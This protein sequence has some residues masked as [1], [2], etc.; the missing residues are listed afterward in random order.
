MNR[1]YLTIKKLLGF[2]MTYGE[3]AAIAGEGPCKRCVGMAVVGGQTSWG[4]PA[5]SSPIEQP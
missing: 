5:N 3:L 4:K 2:T 1:I